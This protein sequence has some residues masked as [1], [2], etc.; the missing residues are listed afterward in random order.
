LKFPE[1]LTKNLPLPL[2]AKEGNK[3]QKKGTGQLSNEAAGISE[4]IKKQIT[5]C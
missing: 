2:F 5:L 3:K 4:V 1:N